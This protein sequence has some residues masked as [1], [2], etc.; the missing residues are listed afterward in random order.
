MTAPGILRRLAA[1]ARRH[2][3]GVVAAVTATLLVGLAGPAY[4]YWTATSTGNA[5]AAAGTLTAPALTAGAVTATGA[6]LSWTQPFAP[7]SYTLSQSPGTLTTCPAAPAAGSTACPATSLTPNTTY[8]WTLSAYV[9]NWVSPVTVSATTPKQATTTTLSA[10]TPTAGA[11]GAAFSATATV[12]GWGSPAGTVLFSLYPNSTCT[13]AASYT[14]SQALSA[15][16]ATAALIPAAGTYYW[17]AG[18]APTDAYNAPST[19][20]CGPSITVTTGGLTYAGGSSQAG[21]NN[22]GQSVTVPY[23]TGTTGAT[24]TKPGDLVLLVLANHGSKGD[25]PPSTGWTLVADSTSTGGLAVWWHAAG[26][27]TGVTL[28]SLGLSNVAW[29]LDYTKATPPVLALDAKVSGVSSAPGAT[30]TPVS[31]TATQA[32]TVISLA[33]INTAGT[34]S[35]QVAQGFGLHAS[36]ATTSRALGVADRYAGTAGS[37]TSPTWAGGS[38]TSSWAYITMGFTS[39]P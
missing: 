16:A 13:G 20:A 36:L 18:Y 25:V 35:L 10:V 19:S 31:L 21:V 32:S 28:S 11:A 33:A 37:V 27:E 34:L 38:A 14:S 12:A 39:G 29:V 23:P 9:H 26:T 22:S 24:L 4:A 5:Q 3:A 30:F 2:R 17:Q 6:T 15:G 1:A 7:T 8:T